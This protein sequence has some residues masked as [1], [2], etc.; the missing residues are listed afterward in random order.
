MKT[1]IINNR[2]IEFD[3]EKNVLEVVRKAGI[4]LPTF[5]YHS[6]LSIYGACRMCIVEDERG[7]IFTSC[8]TIPKDGM[9]ISTHTS[10]L[11]RP[12]ILPLDNDDK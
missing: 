12:T 3:D 8:S 2:A 6:E 11:R 4:D 10:R 5:C 7:N 1:M 9:T